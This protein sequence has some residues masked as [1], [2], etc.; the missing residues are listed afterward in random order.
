MSDRPGAVVPERVSRD[1]GPS[2]VAH[3]D[4][5]L[6]RDVAEPIG[7][8]ERNCPYVGKTFQLVPGGRPD[9]EEDRVRGHVDVPGYERTGQH[10]G[11]VRELR[12]GRVHIDEAVDDFGNPW[13][14][15]RSAGARRAVDRRAS[16][17]QRRP[18]RYVPWSRTVRVPRHNSYY[19]S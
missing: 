18:G 19:Y 9:R 8:R 14:I 3:F 17:E 2:P 7:V 12:F 5:A 4:P 11:H 1:A 15:D 16:L 10:V 6:G 13:S